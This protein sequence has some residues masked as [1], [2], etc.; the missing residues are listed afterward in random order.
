MNSTNSIDQK[1][2]LF[3]SRDGLVD[4][5]TSG[6]LLAFGIGMLTENV[7]LAGILPA[8][9][10]PLWLSAKER[11]TAPRLRYLDE[12]SGNVGTVD[13]A[14]I[15]SALVGMMALLV[16]SLLLG[17]VFFALFSSGDYMP[18]VQAWFRSNFPLAFGTFI[19]LLL[20]GIALIFRTARFL[21]YAA[22][23]L[24]AFVLGQLL[25]LPLE[26]AMLTIAGLM[27]IAGWV[28]LLRFLSAYT[29]QDQR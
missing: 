23:A 18:Q 10:Y 29:P 15:R 5:F 4:I 13:T 22:I 11:I 1:A 21:V 2:Y 7:W 27:F 26:Y 12:M 14:R 20:A 8:L 24:I 3:D 19:S 17:I 6:V 9:L 25:N 28:V 16:G